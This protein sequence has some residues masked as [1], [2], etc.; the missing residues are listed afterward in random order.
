MKYKLVRTIPEI[1][2]ALRLRLKIFYVEQKVDPLIELD[3]DDKNAYHFIA[4]DKK[5][6]VGVARARIMNKK[7]KI[8]RMAIDKKFRSKGVGSGLNKYILNFLKMKNVNVIY[9]HAQY[10]VKDFYKKLGFKI[11]GKPFTEAK[12]KHIK[13]VY[14]K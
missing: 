10:Y 4:I 12:I 13:M 3:T 7:A 8:E 5:K 11:V 2:E 1:V 6:I 14:T 9:L